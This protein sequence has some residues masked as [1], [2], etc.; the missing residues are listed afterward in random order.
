MTFLILAYRWLFPNCFL[1]FAPGCRFHLT[2]LQLRNA[3]I[4]NLLTRKDPYW[5]ELPLHLSARLAL[6]RRMD[7]LKASLQEDKKVVRSLYPLVSYITDFSGITNFLPKEG[8]LTKNVLDADSRALERT[9]T[10]YERFCSSTS[11]VKEAKDTDHNP[12]LEI[13]GTKPRD[14][15]LVTD[16][17]G[18]C[19]NIKKIL[20]F[21][22][23]GIV[24]LHVSSAVTIAVTELG[25]VVKESIGRGFFAT[26][27]KFNDLMLQSNFTKGI[28]GAYFGL[29]VILFLLWLANN[30]R[31]NNYIQK[32]QHN[33]YE[34][35]LPTANSA[36]TQQP[37]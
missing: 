11:E 29:A 22:A 21:T 15:E 26:V 7:K 31:K 35:R 33:D 36:M 1:H 34:Q 19:C 24:T 2:F 9:V 10:L 25:S 23:Q 32:A 12:T 3:A 4:S 37:I 27:T 30:Y 20:N 16:N 28:S 8:K 6:V 18:S 13:K 5:K 14:L 17:S